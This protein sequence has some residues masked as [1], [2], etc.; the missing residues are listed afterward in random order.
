MKHHFKEGDVVNRKIGG[1]LMTV[2]DTRQDEFVA[3]I[4]FDTG[5]HVQRDCFAPVT[6]QKWQLVP[7][8]SE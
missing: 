1:P 7:E 3:T 2:E 4:W 6:L 5:G 8:P